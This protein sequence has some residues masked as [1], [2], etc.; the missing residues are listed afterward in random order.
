MR[1]IK[2][3]N[4]SK[5][6]E[7]EDEVILPPCPREARRS[8]VHARKKAV[9]LIGG[10]KLRISYTLFTILLNSVLRGQ[11]LVMRCRQLDIIGLRLEMCDFC[12]TLDAQC[13]CA[14]PSSPLAS[15]L[16]HRLRK[17]IPQASVPRQSTRVPQTVC[18][19][20]AAI[21]AFV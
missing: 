8:R 5:G 15:L 11:G 10:I 1:G 18:C 21:M 20:V 16:V 12:H 17:Q 7:G 6:E 3:V 9:S 19:W 4:P 14:C 13:R 2:Q